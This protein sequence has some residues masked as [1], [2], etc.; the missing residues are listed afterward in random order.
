M[1]IVFEVVDELKK[2]NLKISTAESC[3]GGLIAS[4]IVDVPGV[5]AFFDEG[6][7]TYSNESK[8]KNLFVDWEILNTYGAVSKEC[9]EAMAEGLHKRTGADIC[10]CSTGIAG[11]DGGSK[12]KP[13][14]TVFLSCYYDGKCRVIENHFT[15]NRSEVRSASTIKAFSLVLECLKKL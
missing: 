14:G 1:D 10:I 9:A 12:E 15:G 8:N 5:S 6:Y 4:S 11:P 7:V 13:V 2:K 3:T